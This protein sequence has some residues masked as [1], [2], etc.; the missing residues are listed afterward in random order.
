MK[1]CLIMDLHFSKVG[2]FMRLSNALKKYLSGIFLKTQNFGFICLFVHSILTKKIIIKIQKV[3]AMFIIK[4]LVIPFHT[5]SLKT[6]KKSIKDS[7]LLQKV[8]ES[9]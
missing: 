3:K 5:M 8:T 9:R 2:N 1:F 7:F 6:K 4:K